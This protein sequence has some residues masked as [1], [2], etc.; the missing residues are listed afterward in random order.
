MCLCVHHAR[1]SCVHALSRSRLWSRS[2]SASLAVRSSDMSSG[3][4]PKLTD[5]RQNGVIAAKEAFRRWGWLRGDEGKRA[6]EGAGVVG[7]WAGGEC[8]SSAATTL[9]RRNNAEN[10][11]YTGGLDTGTGTWYTPG[12]GR[13]VVVDD[14]SR[15]PI[16]VPGRF[17]GG[18][19]KAKR[20][21]LFSPHSLPQHIPHR[22]QNIKTSK[23]TKTAKKSA[24][25]TRNTG[26]GAAGCRTEPRHNK[27]GAATDCR[28]HADLSPH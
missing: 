14:R 6:G 5:G 12:A 13:V 3:S 28:P 10:V 24:R 11:Y 22:Q 16:L 9:K 2:R 17:F 25:K 8:Q 1:R 23:N 18:E 27:T 4:R 21:F 7:L 19:K 20:F 15:V 26:T